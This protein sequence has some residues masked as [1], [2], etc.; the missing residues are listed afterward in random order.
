MKIRLQANIV[1]YYESWAIITTDSEGLYDKSTGTNNVKYQ[2]SEC[3][4]L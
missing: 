4:E 2:S 1:V 3:V